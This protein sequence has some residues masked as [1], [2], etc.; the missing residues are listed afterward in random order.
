MPEISRAQL[1]A[2][3]AVAVLVVA[4]GVRFM[5]RQRP[6]SAAAGAAPA[7]AS[8]SGSDGRSTGA[9]R[10]ERPPAAA[11]TVHVA[12]AVRRPGVYRL[13]AGARVE[14]A[15][16]RAGGARP[17]G[18]VNAINLAA[19]VVDGQQVVVPSR[20][21]AGAAVSAA[22]AGGAGAAPGAPVSL[23]SA[24]AEQLDTLDGVGPATARKIIEWRSQHGGF[25][26]VADLGQVPGIGPK[27]LAALRGKVQ[28]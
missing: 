28:P 14:D 21:G 17:R 23:N 1:V 20:G 18:D 13:P 22:A 4:L 3:A 25:R 24:T 8:A 26:S 27:K 19:K 11:A 2:Y 5:Q 9:V 15:V 6:A 16:R 10:I 12:G 7:G